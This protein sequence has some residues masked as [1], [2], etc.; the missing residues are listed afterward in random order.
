M[1]H[2]CMA[3]AAMFVLVQYVI[4]IQIWEAVTLLRP[5]ED[6]N[7]IYKLEGK[8]Q[9]IFKWSKCVQSAF[10]LIFLGHFKGDYKGAKEF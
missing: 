4:R 1:S 3:L 5:K 6:V 2:V 7:N 10:H 8:S 9:N